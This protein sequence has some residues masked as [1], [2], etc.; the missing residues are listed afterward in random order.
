MVKAHT[1]DI[2]VSTSKGY[3]TYHF[4]CSEVTVGRSKEVTLTIPLAGMSRK[5][6]LIT[7][8]E[9]DLMIEDLGSA[10]GTS[11]KGKVLIPKIPH[12]FTEGD[13][14]TI[15]G[16]DV[17]FNVFL[18]FDESEDEA[19][20]NVM[21]GDAT[22]S[23]NETVTKL[24]KDVL[25]EMKKEQQKQKQEL[26]FQYEEDEELVAAEKAKENDLLND[27]EVQKNDESIVDL[28]FNVSEEDL[29]D[30]KKNSKK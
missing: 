17:K 18:T 14:I 30:P 27:E 20:T 21:F 26:Q 19:A 7:A 16:L 3:K 9:D 29:E 1:V 10:N 5:H 13:E 24:K 6:F 25:D 12:P 11:L 15:P 28:E 23:G 8:V 4:A 2:R 22:R